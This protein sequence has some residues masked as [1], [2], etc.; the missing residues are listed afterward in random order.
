[1]IVEG[2]HRCIVIQRSDILPLILP[3]FNR[4]KCIPIPM[5]WRCWEGRNEKGLTTTIL[6]FIIVLEPYDREKSGNR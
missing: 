3:A 2:V 5:Y 6:N 4:K 1:M